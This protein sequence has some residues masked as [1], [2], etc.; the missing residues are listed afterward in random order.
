MKQLNELEERLIALRFPFLQIQE[1][2][3]KYKGQQMGLTR[4]VINV[5]TNT[6]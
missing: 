4:G 1:L 6:F 3:H 2:G 5:P